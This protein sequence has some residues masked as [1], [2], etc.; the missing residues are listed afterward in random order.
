LAAPFWEEIE[1]LPP[2]GKELYKALRLTYGSALVN[3]PFAIIVANNRSLI[4]LN[5][6]IKLRPLVAARHGDMFYISSEEAAIHEACPSPDNVWSPK[7]GEPVVG[8]LK[9]VK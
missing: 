2:D 4:G 6:R 5:D 9:G 7:A 3:G 8:R 1:R